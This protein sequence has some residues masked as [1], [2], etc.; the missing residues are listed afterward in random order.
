M[1]YIFMD[2][3]GD[4]GFDSTKSKT[5]KYF[6]ITFLFTQE[7]KP[8]E[9]VIKKVFSSFSKTELKHHSGTLHC[10]K[11]KPATRQK[12]LQSLA[13][14]DV[15]VIT[16]LLN[17]SKVYTRLHDE[18]HF[19]YNYVTNI[20]LD[21]ICTKK[22]I[23]LDGPVRLV[24]AKRETN[25]FLNENFKDYLCVQARDNHKV[26]LE[27]DICH[28]SGEKSLQLVDFACWA[29]FRKYEHGDD[30]YYALIKEKIAEENPLF[31]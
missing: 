28:P 22:I 12:V 17:K 27:V 6:V 8:L 15:S 4:L 3:S 23:P 14:K 20:L 25:R 19:L 16:I 7:K 24:A 13:A 18:K 9:K 31:P 5:S 21:R 11:E 10:Y 2:E 30:T 26:Q 1:A 29:V